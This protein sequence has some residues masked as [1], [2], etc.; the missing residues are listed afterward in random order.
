MKNSAQNSTKIKTKDAEANARIIQAAQEAQ[1]AQTKNA[2][3]SEKILHEKFVLYGAN[4]R[5]WTRK[6]ALLLP[7]IE[8]REIWKKRGFGS[9]YEYAAKLAGMSRD[10]VDGALWTLQKTENKPELRKAIEEK[11]ITSVRL[12]ANLATQETDKFWAEKVRE[13]SSYT[14]AAYAKEFRKSKNHACFETEILSIKQT[15]NISMELELGVAEQLQKLKGQSE[16]SNLMKKLLQA[17]QAQVEAEKPLPEEIPE[18]A[19]S[20]YIPAK[21]K[22]Y[23]LAKTNGACAFP[24][25]YKPYE[26]LHHT[27]GFALTHSH[28]PD[29]LVPLCRAHERLAHLGLIENENKPPSGWRMRLAPDK[30]NGKYF[31]D[32]KTMKYRI[33]LRR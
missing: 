5:E 7:E 33:I 28:N 18:K 6:C 26:I 24:S 13:M 11:G 23:A 17:Y 10:A 3:Q 15:Q 2:T 4:A 27:D 30:T 31:I 19:K 32:Q 12:I 1:T 9:I 25:C 21:I 29:K 14:L 22:S 20:R 8:R 16:W